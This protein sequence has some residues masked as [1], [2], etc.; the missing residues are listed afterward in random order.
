MVLTFLEG[1]REK[2]R[3]ACMLYINK[4]NALHFDMRFCST[5]LVY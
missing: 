2:R 4:K 1:I 3:A 5:S